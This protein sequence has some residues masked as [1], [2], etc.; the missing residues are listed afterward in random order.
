[1][2]SPGTIVGPSEVGHRE[3]RLQVDQ[4]ARGR[5]L[6]DAGHQ[7]EGSDVVLGEDPGQGD[8][9]VDRE[10]RQRQGR[11]HAVRAEQCLEAPP[12]VLGGEAVEG[13]VVLPLVVVHPAEDLRTD[14]AERHRGGGADGDAVADAADLHG[15]LVGA[16]VEQGAAQ[17]ADHRAATL[18]TRRRIGAWARWHSASATASAASTGRKRL[19]DPEQHLHHPLDLVL[20]RPAHAGDGLLHLV[21]RV[22]DHLAAGRDRLRHRDPGGLGDGDRG[23]GVHLEQHPLDGDHRRA[24]LVEERAQIGLELGEPLGRGQRRLGAQHPDGHRLRPGRILPHQPVAAARETGVDPEHV[25]AFDRSRGQ[26][27]SRA[28]LKGLGSGADTTA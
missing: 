4:E 2:G 12:L 27:R 1:M 25:H 11:P 28:D 26:A 7:A 16:A 18:A 10:D 20:R 13:D 21:R 5:L 8:R 17:R 22:L 6:A 3:A 19:A 15:D 23:A 9:R 24:V 14:V